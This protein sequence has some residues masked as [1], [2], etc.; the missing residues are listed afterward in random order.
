MSGEVVSV[1]MILDRLKHL[2]RVAK[3]GTDNA[4]HDLLIQLLELLIEQNQPRRIR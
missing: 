3:S 4:T 1:P 2:L